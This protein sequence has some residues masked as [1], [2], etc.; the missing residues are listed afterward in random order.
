M[1]DDTNN[2]RSRPLGYWLRTVDD[3]ISA[4]FAEALATEEIGRREWILLTL[5]S[6][7]VDAPGAAERL[8]RHGKKLRSLRDR[9]WIAEVDGAWTLTDEGRAAKDRLAEKIAEVRD[10]V[11]AAVSPEDLATTLASLEAIARR[12]GGDGIDARGFGG[13]GR[14][15]RGRGRGHRHGHDFERHGFGPGFRAGFGP[16]FQPGSGPGFRP[17]A[18]V[19]PRDAD[20]AGCGHD[21]HGHGHGHD[22]DGH[23]HGHHGRPARGFGTADRRA[24]ADAPSAPASDQRS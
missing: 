22:H 2:P 17:G 24:D 11:A 4:R 6:G 3:L 5:V 13:H 9:G 7:D 15:G 16:G 19:D 20:E 12:L 10:E 18:D 14:R 8:A 1:E 23:G 21:R